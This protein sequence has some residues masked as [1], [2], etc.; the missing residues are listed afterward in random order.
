MI[1]RIVPRKPLAGSA[2]IQYHRRGTNRATAM[3]HRPVLKPPAAHSPAHAAYAAHAAHAPSAV[4]AGRTE[5][6]AEEQS[7][8]A[9]M[10]Q[11]ASLI[12]ASKMSGNVKLAKAMTRAT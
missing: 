2:S 8:D 7:F 11:A 10:V 4:G 5:G 12:A 3:M 6:P 9:A 1:R